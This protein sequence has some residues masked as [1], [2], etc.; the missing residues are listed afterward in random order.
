MRLPFLIALVDETESRRCTRVRLVHAAG[1]HAAWSRGRTGHAAG[2]ALRPVPGVRRQT[3]EQTVGR[4]IVLGV[5]VPFFPVVEEL[6]AEVVVAGLELQGRLDCG[7]QVRRTDHRAGDR[8]VDAQVGE[9][10][11]GWDLVMGS[12]M[13]W[14]DTDVCSQWVLRRSDR[15]LMYAVNR[16]YDGMSACTGF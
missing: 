6:H 8:R 4:K 13:E 12:T 1:R 11:H 14:S 2:V 10:V 16:F 7:H 9:H 3:G 15:T 5:L